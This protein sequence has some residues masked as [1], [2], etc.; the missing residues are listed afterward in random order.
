MFSGFGLYLQVSL[1]CQLLGSWLEQSH[2]YSG[3][4]CATWKGVFTRCLD[5]C[6]LPVACHLIFSRP[7]QMEWSDWCP[8]TGTK[9]RVSR[10]ET[11]TAM[12][13]DKT[14]HML[15]MRAF[16]YLLHFQM[17]AVGT[18]GAAILADVSS[19]VIQVTKVFPF[20]GVMSGVH[21]NTSAALCIPMLFERRSSGPEQ[22]ATMGKEGAQH[23]IS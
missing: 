18:T 15:F 20:G 1:C 19:T 21:C 8:Q 13:E 12:S 16:L 6:F 7:N 23:K 17:E 9:V 4:V 11:R 5:C 2:I 3:A 14:W 22:L 10:L